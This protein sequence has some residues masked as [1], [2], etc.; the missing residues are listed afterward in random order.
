MI[1]MTIVIITIMIIMK[2]MK[3]KEEIRKT[4]VDFL[5]MKEKRRNKKNTREGAW[6]PSCLQYTSRLLDALDFP[7][8]SMA[9]VRPLML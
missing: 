6:K 2:L 8:L 3:E 4:H 7:A 1:I 9:Q 5:T